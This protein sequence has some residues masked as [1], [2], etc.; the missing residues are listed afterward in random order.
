MKRS[1]RASHAIVLGRR[2]GDQLAERTFA[3]ALRGWP[4]QTVRCAWSADDPLGVYSGTFIRPHL[5]GIFIL[6]VNVGQACLDSIEFVT[7]DTAVKDLAATRQRV[8]MPETTFADQWY[9]EWEIL[10]ADNQKTFAV[11]LN[12]YLMLCVV[13]GDETV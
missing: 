9:R 12:R 3:I 11:I 1:L 7:T 10:F 5:F 13:C 8:E 6:R 2:T 4:V